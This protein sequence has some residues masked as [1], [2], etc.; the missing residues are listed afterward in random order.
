MLRKNELEKIPE[1]QKAIINVLQ[2]FNFFNHS[3]YLQEIHQYLSIKTSQKEVLKNLEEIYELNI[4]VNRDGLWALSN[5]SL[6]IRI[7]NLKRNSRLLRISKRMGWL[8]SKFPFV[9]GVYL[10]GSLSKLGAK[11][12]NDDIDYFIITEPNRT[13]TTKLIL[14]MFRRLF[15]FNSHKYFCPNYIIDEKHLEL[16]I[17][18]IYTAI[19]SASL[20]VLANKG[21]LG[22]FYEK[23]PFIQDYFPNFIP[24]KA[25]TFNNRISLSEILIPKYQREIYYRL[26]GTE[27]H[28]A[29]IWGNWIEKKVRK[30][31]KRRHL[32]LSLKKYGNSEISEW[33]MGQWIS[34]IQ[35]RVLEN[36]NNK[37]LV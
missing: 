6:D 7:N 5:E 33:A 21:L 17:K 29:N 30:I 22:K 14:G 25:Y 8:I 12:D 9:K 24:E 16:K 4:I 28:P 10:S 35:D 32:N 3:L 13:Y 11:S 26:F 27:N 37:K 31:M 34:N 23:N 18:N 36:Y 1:I 19:E 20:I 15:L 2:Y